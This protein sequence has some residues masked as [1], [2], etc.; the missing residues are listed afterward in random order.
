MSP[1]HIT[2]LAPTA[3]TVLAALAISLSACKPALPTSHDAL[4]TPPTS[5]PGQGLIS[6]DSNTPCPGV[7]VCTQGGHCVDPTGQ[8][9]ATEALQADLDNLPAPVGLGTP[10][11]LPPNARLRIDD[12][13]ND[14]LALH[15]DRRI[16]LDGHG[17]QFVVENDIIALRISQPADWSSVRDLSFASQ[18]PSQAHQGIGLDVR[19]HGLRLDN[20]YFDRMGTGIRAH[21]MVDGEHA[22]LN[23]QQWSRI[24][25]YECH[26][27]A[28]H[29]AGGDSNAGL[30]SGLEVRAGNGILDSSFL[31]NT[32]VSPTI[33]S[34]TVDALTLDSTASSA[35]VL[36]AYTEINAPD[37]QA[38]SFHDLHLGGNAIDRLNSEG[39]RIGRHHASLRF[40]HPAT[41]LR[42][43]IP[44]AAHAAIAFNHPLDGEW[45]Y[46]RFFDEPSR[47]MWGFSYRNTS[48][49]AYRFTGH[50][51]P[52]GPALYQLGNSLASA[53]TTSLA[54]STSEAT[55]T[56]GGPPAH[57]PAHG[58]RSHT[59]TAPDPNWDGSE[60]PRSE[61]P[62]YGVTP[63]ESA[64]FWDGM[65]AP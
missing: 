26:N 60:P 5:Q 3:F 31:G 47:R 33:N 48:T 45:W 2:L 28:A 16:I 6:C 62:Y 19:A 18:T 38:H 61:D 30:F 63:D 21:S 8:V 25:F 54:T 56:S 20:L 27:Y 9:S 23:I 13:D 41:G 59:P 29:L 55:P 34:T 44:G 37:M 22:N 15:V 12:P 32:Y 7:F 17:A 52:Q 46:L 14:G 1:P 49:S 65:P 24:V 53:T 51:H 43:R 64:F 36:G 10:Y 50:Q 40:R 4:P 39:D 42:V 57:A 58:R 11:R 35:T